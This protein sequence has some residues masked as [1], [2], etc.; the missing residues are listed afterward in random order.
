MN[1]RS[2]QPDASASLAAL[3]EQE[4]VRQ[5][6]TGTELSLRKCSAGVTDEY[7]NALLI[8]SRLG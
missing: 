3:A 4:G 6:L 8:A 7:R 1:H 2:I 5:E